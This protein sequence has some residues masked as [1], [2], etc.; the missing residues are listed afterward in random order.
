[1]VYCGTLFFWGTQLYHLGNSHFEIGKVNETSG[2]LKTNGNSHHKM[3]FLYAHS[4]ISLVKLDIFNILV[5]HVVIAVELLTLNKAVILCVCV[6]D[7]LAF[8]TSVYTHLRRITGFS[9]NSLDK[10]Y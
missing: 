9:D 2:M 3:Y 7:F 1:M 8:N 10:N 4:R 5:V 6:T